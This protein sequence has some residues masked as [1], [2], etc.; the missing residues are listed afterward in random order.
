MPRHS[1]V[2]IIPLLCAF[3]LPASAE[4]AVDATTFTCAELAEV[5]ASGSDSDHFGG[6]ALLS[7]MAGYHASEDQGTV[8]DFD[9]L[10]KDIQRTVEFCKKNPRIGVYTAS[11]KFMGENATEASSEAIDLATIKCQRIVDTADSNDNEGLGII[12]MWLAGYYAS[13][14][15]DKMIDFDKLKTEG[16]EIGKACAQSRETGLVTVADKFMQRE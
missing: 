15:G 4:N 7:W 12:L 11:E 9:G 6:A 14:A 10:K 8:V 13:Y 1:L 3:S 2:A 16:Y 5:D